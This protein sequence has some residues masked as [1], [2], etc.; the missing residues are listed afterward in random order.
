MLAALRHG[1]FRWL[2]AAQA[3]SSFGNYAF[4]VS[5]AALLVESGETAGTIGLV[6]ALDALGVVVFALPAGVI[7]D[8]L[9]RTRVMI[10]ADFMRMT[11][12]AAIA[13]AG[14]GAPIA[15][16][17]ALAFV[18]GAGQAAFEPA[19]R[20]L[21]PRVLPDELLQSGNA[22]SALSQQLSL[23]M[24]PAISGVVIAL[25]SPEAALATSATIF[26]LSWLA[27]FRVRETIPEAG[28]DGGPQSV[29]TDVAEGLR[30]FRDRFWIAVVVATAMVH[31]LVAIAPF[32]VL[33]PLI[34]ENGYGDVAIYGWMLAAMGAGS[35][36]GAVIGSRIRPRLPGVVSLLA[37]IPFC[38]LLAALAIEPA[39][40]LLLGL[41]FL[42]GMGEAVFDVL[43]TTSLQ[44]DVPDR[45]LSR[46]I[47]IDFLGSLALLPIGL[48][49]TGPAVDAFG[50][51]E[52]LIFGA[53]LS[54]VLIFPPLL[55][56]S[57]RRFSSA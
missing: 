50:Q 8:R 18:T 17:A 52:V 33:T 31:L 37:L 29:L 5:V 20:G 39:L 30:A 4:A 54:F 15:L 22:L 7:G 24:G 48:A 51:D 57:V 44:R 41:L 26:A 2:F 27:A 49:L 46:V 11:S 21:M 53:A 1:T 55:S 6:L 56:E 32:D 23:F 19:Y 13:I 40:A 14:G 16:I 42:T 45:L 10:G 35:V 36:V 25:F 38:V 43:W 12:V 28:E 3:A 9:P 34:A 47:S